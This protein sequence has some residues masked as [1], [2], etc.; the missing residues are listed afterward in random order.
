[1]KYFVL[2]TASIFMLSANAEDFKYFK[3]D[4]N[5]WGE[6][7]KVI[8]KEEP[9]KVEEVPTKQSPKEDSFTLKKYQSEHNEEFWKEGN[10]VTP[11]IV[12][13]VS[14]IVS[15][16]NSSEK[17]KKRAIKAYQ[18]WINKKNKMK[19]E[20]IAALIKYS[21][22]PSLPKESKEYMRSMANKIPQQNIDTEKMTFTMFFRS[23]CPHCKRMFETFR[24]LH[25]K[26]FYVEA[27]Q[28]DNLPMKMRDYP[29]IIEKASKEEVDNLNKSGVTGVPFTL[30]FIQGHKTLAVN[31]FQTRETL[32]SLISNHINKG[33]R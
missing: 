29:F 22:K 6:D 3:S 21:E 24:E 18:N 7:K 28:I 4:I 27:K 19:N 32:F 20:F 12:Q 15:D 8:L 14:I 11:K 30:V 10:H 1:M 23:T 2:I 5:Y 16:K 33:G 25:H 13:K 9:K 31:G 26:G 17:D